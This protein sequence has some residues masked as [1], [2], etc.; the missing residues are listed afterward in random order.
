MTTERQLHDNYRN[1]AN[2]G[3]PQ[4][5]AGFAAVRRTTLMHGL[6]AAKIILPTTEETV[7]FEQVRAACK[8]AYQLNAIVDLSHYNG[9][10]DLA[11]ASQAGIRGLIQK[12]TQGVTFVD[13]TFQTNFAQASDA[14]LLL[15]AYHFGTG[16]D[17]VA[18]A[19]HFLNT[20]QPDAKTLLVLDFENNPT[21]PSM[22]LEE[23][24]AFVT[25]VQQAT[26][27][28]P[29][30]YSGHYIKDLLGSSLDS[31]L[32][33]CWFWLAQYGP[34]PVIPANWKNWTMWQ[35]TD[36]AAGNPPY[37]VPGIGRCN[38]DMFAGDDA[39]LRLFWRYSSTPA[40]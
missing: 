2:S 27:R 20:V 37:E 9:V 28:W 26:G 19:E 3:G 34:T 25:H 10:V 17:G 23:A 24:R 35:Y 13:P 16:D 4:T 32:A 15:G 14:G 21:G 5:A 11:Q 7:D 30:F 12:A 31:I 18:Q 33:N 22:N 6:T 38:R 1:A 36:G 40:A 29:G 8:D 39:G